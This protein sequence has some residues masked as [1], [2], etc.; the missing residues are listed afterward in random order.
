LDRSC[1]TA[2]L[3][4]GTRGVAPLL[5]LLPLLAGAVWAN[6]IPPPVSPHER[7]SFVGLVIAVE[8]LAVVL[9]AIPL[10]L[11]AGW[12]WRQ[13]LGGSLLMNSVSFVVGMAAVRFARDA[14]AHAVQA[15]V[16]GGVVF[17]EGYLPEW[18][19][20]LVAFVVGAGIEIVVASELAR[21]WTGKPGRAMLVCAATHCVTWPAV[22]G[23]FLGLT[24]AVGPSEVLG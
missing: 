20:A 19:L 3:T 9:E 21:R 15:P 16:S 6:P 12:T 2:F 10:N 14:L 17:L 1:L 11:L 4:R 7:H 22:Y 18:F 5:V 23:A 24:T 8:L 13:A